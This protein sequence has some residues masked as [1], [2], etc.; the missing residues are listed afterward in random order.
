MELKKITIYGY[1]KLENLTFSIHSPIHVFYGENEAGKS[2]IMSFIHSILF[3]F[4]TKQQ[5]ELRYEPKLQHKYGGK[6]E[7]YFPKIGLATIERVKGKATGDVTVTLEDGRRGQEELL[8]ELLAG[9]DKSLYQSIFSFNLHGLQNVQQLKGEELGRFLFSTGA[10][11]SDRLLKAENELQKELDLRYKP[12]GKKPVVNEKLQDLRDKHGQ[13]KVAEKDNNQYVQLLAKKRELEKERQLTEAELKQEEHEIRYLEEWIKIKEIA[14]EKDILEEKLAAFKELNFPQN[15]LT[16]WEALKEKLLSV[17]AELRYLEAKALE[18]E[19]EMTSLPIQEELIK[20][21][22]DIILA[23]EKFPVYEQLQNRQNQVQNQLKS[24][25]EEINS[26]KSKL[27]LPIEEE[28]LLKE[29]NTSIFLKEQC[30]QAASKQRR[31]KEQK[32][33]LDERLKDE[34]TTLE[35]LEETVKEYKQKLLPKDER[36][37]LEEHVKSDN[38][39]RWN[40]EK[41]DLLLR[42]IKQLEEQVKVEEKRIKQN[43]M[44][45]SVLSTFLLL[46]GAGA[47][48]FEQWFLTLISFAISIVYFL[49]FLSG[50]KLAKNEIRKKKKRIVLIKEE[51]AQLLAIMEKGQG[52]SPY[53]EQKLEDDTKCREKFTQLQFKL[54]QQNESYERVLQGFEKW[55]ADFLSHQKLLRQLANELRI[56]YELATQQIYDAF[57]LIEEWKAKDRESNS[58]YQ[59]LEEIQQEREQ[60]ISKIIHLFEKFI[61]MEKETIANMCYRLKTALTEEKKKKDRIETLQRKQDDLSEHMEKYQTEYNRYAEEKTALLSI[62]G[63]K[64]EEAFLEKAALEKERDTYKERLSTIDVQLEIAHISKEQIPLYKKILDPERQLD[65]KQTKIERLASRLKELVEEAAA[66]NFTLSRIESGGTYTDLLHTFKQF[67]SEFK[68]DVREWAKFAVAKQLLAKTVEQY[69]Q[70][71]LPA[72]LQKAEENLAFLTE[73]KYIRILPK[74]E[75]AG[76]LVESHQHVFYEAKELSQGTTEQLYLSIRIALAQT[77]YKSFWFPF[78]IDDSFVNFDEKRTEKVIQLLKKCEQNQLIFST[79]HRHL[80]KHFPDNSLHVLPAEERE[81][82]L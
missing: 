44:I 55:E 28:I 43:T 33:E 25:E 39:V 4:P 75:G 13:L 82:S 10:V 29:S 42:E 37:R 6:L 61:G 27:H 60:I 52:I 20:S 15:G 24:I 73:G 50:R 31:L 72:M 81:T 51:R 67:Q 12:S 46:V 58:I 11:G 36:I 45:T 80:L 14:L 23:V 49:V 68:E 9:M 2:T 77:F 5:T 26:L 53:E 8:N 76:F 57:L 17:E 79:C 63:V 38:Q 70:K 22:K 47:L 40:K 7:I 69:K 59:E 21:E 1:G 64:E 78:I 18:I 19:Q 48:F 35:L 32:E 62:A 3:G 65:E 16:R 71:Q 74:Q 66:I 41:A 54:E 30:A 56:P 34:Q